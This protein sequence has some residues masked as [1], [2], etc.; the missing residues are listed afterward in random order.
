[1]LLMSLLEIDETCE[2]RSASVRE[3]NVTFRSAPIAC[4][5]STVPR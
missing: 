4:E 3:V 5:I 1:M 2:A